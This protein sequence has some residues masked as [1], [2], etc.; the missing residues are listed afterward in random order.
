[1]ME[2]DISPELQRAFQGM[3][4]NSNPWGI[5]FDKRDE[6]AEGLEVPRMADWVSDADASKD[7]PPLLFWVGCAGSFDDRTKKVTQ[8]M[9]QILKA[10]EVP[11]AILGKEEGCTGDPARRSGNEYLFQELAATNVEVLNNY[12]VKKVLTTCP[13]CLHT[14]KREYPQFEGN[15]E[16]VHHTELIDQLIAEGKLNLKDDG[17]KQSLALHDSCY[18]GRYH[19][20]YEAPRNVVNAVPGWISSS[21]HETSHARFVVVP[22]A[23]VSGWRSISVSVS[24][25]T[26]LKRLRTRTRRWSGANC[27]FC[28]TMISDGMKA[29][30]K[31]EVETLDIAL[32][33]LHVS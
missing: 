23:V 18:L 29:V 27:P 8:A 21:F 28:L 31:E 14:I 6:W 24:M 16:V 32:R 25:C 5:G 12:G 1:M 9:V 17:D 30:G 22:V 3:E 15:F 20:I 11:F 7:N 2:G 26:A 33:L 4:N 13:H 19:D 10:A